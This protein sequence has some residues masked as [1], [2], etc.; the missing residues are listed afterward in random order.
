MKTYTDL[1]VASQ[2]EQLLHTIEKGITTANEAVVKA[3]NVRLTIS[4]DA[5]KC[6]EIRANNHVAEQQ[7]LQLLENIKVA[8]QIRDELNLQLIQIANYQC[9]FEQL[10]Q[11][12]EVINNSI[13]T[14]QNQARQLEAI[15]PESTKELPQQL[16]EFKQLASQVVIYKQEAANVL[17]QIQDQAK[18]A[19]ES[20]SQNQKIKDEVESIIKDFGGKEK[21]D[22]LQLDYNTVCHSFKA[23][24]TEIEHLHKHFETQTKQQSFLRKW[25]IAI[26]IGVAI[27]SSIVANGIAFILAIVG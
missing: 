27:L 9:T 4:E 3:N 25:M 15:L 10:K 8:T 26:S 17:E 23:A 18:L 5:Q 1:E 12:L 13:N 20:H 7:Q 6:E 2:L 16:E 14:A 11:E 24:Q 19:V 21:F 22:K